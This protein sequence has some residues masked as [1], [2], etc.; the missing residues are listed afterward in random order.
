MISAMMLMMAFTTSLSRMSLGGFVL[1]ATCI[2]S[3]RCCRSSSGRQKPHSISHCERGNKKGT[4][5]IDGS[6][7]RDISL[8]L[9]AQVAYI[10]DMRETTGIKSSRLTIMAFTTDAFSGGGQREV[11]V[12]QAA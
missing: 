5:T 2:D 6:R 7:Q 4:D 3:I 12:A 1:V 11:V 8:W 10:S 9:L